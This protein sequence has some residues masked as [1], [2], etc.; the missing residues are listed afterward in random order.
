MSMLFHALLLIP[1]S[2]ATSSTVCHAPEKCSSEPSE[3]L[4]DMHSLRT[5][6]ALEDTSAVEEILSL[7][8]LRAQ[9]LKSNAS[10]QENVATSG[11]CDCLSYDIGQGPGCQGSCCG[12]PG[13]GVNAPD[14]YETDCRG[15]YQS[16]RHCNAKE[17]FWQQRFCLW[18]EN[19]QMG[20]WGA[21]G[22]CTQPC[23]GG[24]HTR[25]RPVLVAQAGRGTPC[26]DTSETA[27]CNPQ[28][29][30]IDCMWDDWGSWGEC[31]Q[32]CGSGSQSR[33]RSEAR[34]AANGGAACD[35]DITESQECNTQQC[36]VD[37]QWEA[38]SSWGAC[39]VTCG[40][41]QHTRSRSEAI[42][43]ANGGTACVGD[44]T[45]IQSCNEQECPTPAPTPGTCTI[46]GDPH[47]VGFDKAPSLLSALEMPSIQKGSFKVSDTWLVKSSP[48]HIQ[49]R[50]QAVGDKSRVFLK[51]IGVGGPFLQNNT[52][53]IGDRGGKSFWNQQE[54]LSSLPSEFHNGI[55]SAKYHSASELVQDPERT[56]AGVDVELPLGVKL[57]VN[58]GKNGLGIR[59]TTPKIEGGQDGEC[60]NFNGN[61]QDD[62]AELTSKRIGSEIMSGELLL[63]QS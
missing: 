51:M 60:G 14:G 17:N 62:T 3:P 32:S 13:G 11:S 58:Q 37:C 2:V 21:W 50:Y 33:S 39:S 46:Y 42:S 59:I 45:D 20:N 8:Q 56:T 12:G 26:G 34:S 15:S 57:L 30:P 25:T 31:S 28:A 44:R 1:A 5:S 40:G 53:I 19:C 55:V 22:T 38:W 63:P 10:D 36:P 47:V 4:V 9:H 27:A 7:V 16:D 23:G 24:Q 6:E 54:I 49:A 61:G 43:A 41:G 35:G 48:I 29:C 18:N 52:L